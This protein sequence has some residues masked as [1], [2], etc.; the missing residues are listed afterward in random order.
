MLSLNQGAPLHMV[1]SDL[2]K[3]LWSS[4]TTSLHSSKRQEE[5]QG[6]KFSN[7]SSCVIACTHALR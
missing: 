5:V 1:A 2:L 6:G 3:L 7:A 4:S